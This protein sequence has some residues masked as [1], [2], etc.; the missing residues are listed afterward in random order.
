[1]HIL[2]ELHATDS[3]EIRLPHNLSTY[4]R[5]LITLFYQPI[6][7]ADA[8][9]MYLT[10]WTEAEYETDLQVHY[11]L[12][13]VLGQPLRKIFE[14]RATLEAIGL[15]RT[16]SK[17]AD[18]GQHF[19]Y[20]LVRPLDADKFFN[21][22]LLSMFLFSKIGEPA[23][24]KLRARFIRP[25]RDD[26]YREV[27]RSFVDVFVPVQLN[28]PQ[29]LAQPPKLQQANGY[30]FYYTNFDF[31]L[32]R[33]GLSEQLVP[34]AALTQ[35]AKELIAKLAFLYQLTPLDMQKVVI[36]A[37]D[38]QNELPHKRLVQEARAH[39][40]MTKSKDMPL[41]EKRI[42]LQPQEVAPDNRTLT[43]DEQKHLYWA[44]TSPIDALRNLSGDKEP[45]RATVEIVE[46]LVLEYG[47][48]I[49]VVNAL[50]E[51]VML[52]TDMKLPRKYVE[53]IAGH[54]QRKNVTTAQ[55]AMDLARTEHDQYRAWKEKDATKATTA[56]KYTPKQG[57]VRVEKLPDWF[58]TRHE[59]TEEQLSKEQEEELE[60]KRQQMLE[61]L[62]LADGE[63]GQ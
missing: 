7:G 57:S 35:S 17:P 46:A 63:V 62:G 44:Q 21:D 55:Q 14:S 39:Y 51:Y 24:R 47:L 30:P 26:A 4:E 38:E 52:T 11:Y 34:A 56:R 50:V 36:A 5:Q 43:K 16:F 32:L 23:Y 45:P 40:K 10:M 3:Y 28:M 22:P 29:D 6:I 41:L 18:T 9:T 59:K 42:Q 20:E 12:M 13:N 60:A 33:A 27:T 61:S 53:T 49:Q 58:E 19:L 2:N 25:K 1:M 48:E 37:L 31:T 54:W 15:L 8:V